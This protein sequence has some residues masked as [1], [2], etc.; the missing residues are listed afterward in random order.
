MWLSFSA[1]ETTKG[2]CPAAAWDPPTRR[3]DP[4]LGAPVNFADI[5]CYSYVGETSIT[6]PATEATRTVRASAKCMTFNG[7]KV[8]FSTVV[9][10][11]NFAELIEHEMGFQ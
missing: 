11:F 10:R 1:I 9:V 4:L 6:A 5:I 7:F 2:N 3:P 8:H